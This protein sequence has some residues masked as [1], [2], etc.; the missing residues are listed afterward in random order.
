[1]AK[2]N[3]AKLRNRETVNIDG[4]DY[5]MVVGQET[6]DL[7]NA[8]DLYYGERNEYAVRIVRNKDLGSVYPTEFAYAYD[9]G[10]CVGIITV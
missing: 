7:L 8:G 3:L 4:V 1:M 9:F 6:G 10:E 2:G 5:R